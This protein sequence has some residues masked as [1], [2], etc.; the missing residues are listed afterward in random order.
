MDDA[1]QRVERWLRRHGL[2]E[3]IAPPRA[4]RVVEFALVGA[5]G[6]GVNLAVFLPLAEILHFAVAGFV[7]YYVSI[8][9]NFGLNRVVTFDRPD[10]HVPRQYVKYIAMHVF[11]LAVYLALL[12]ATI[13]ILGWPHVIADLLAVTVSGLVN[14]AGAEFYAFSMHRRDG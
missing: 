11:G 10:G 13:D 12:G 5:T 7:A 2:G 8:S 4:V 14:F 9:W 1:E 6:V 3:Y